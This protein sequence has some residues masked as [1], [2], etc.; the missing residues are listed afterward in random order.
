MNQLSIASAICLC[1]ILSGLSGCSKFDQLNTNPNTPAKVS[2]DMLATTLI[3]D[4]TKTTYHSGTDFV[5]P[6]QLGK[7][8]CWSS[9]PSTEQ[10]NYFGRTDWTGLTILNNVSKMISFAT[11]P[12]LKNSYTALGHCMRALKFFYMTLQVGDI[13]YSQ[14]LTG[15]SDAVLKPAYDSQKNVFLGIL[16]ELDQA[17]SLF[18]IG[19]NFGGD[20]V[21]NGDITH[22]RKMA[23]SFQLQVLIN[24]YKKTTDPDLQVAQRFAQIV[25]NRPIFQSNADNFSLVF[26]DAA[27][28]RYPF[29][30]VGNQSYVYV[31]VSS[32][33]IDSLK[34]LNDNRLYYYANP[35]PVKIKAG[36]LP[37]DPSAYSGPDPASPYSNITAIASS[38]DYSPI[39]DRYLQLPQGEP[40][41]MLS[42]AQ[43]KFIIAEA[44]IRGW[45][46]DTGE[47][48]YTDGITAAMHCVLDNT[49]DDPR[50]N[51][52]VKITDTYIQN[53]YLT[54]P[55]VAFSSDKSEQ[56]KQVW[57]QSYLSIFLQAPYTAYYEYR[58]TGYPVFTIN[59]A[60][61]LN[62][63]ADKIPNR[64]LYPQSELDYN[65]QNVVD[66]IQRQ[67]AGDDN[68]NLQM[69]LLQN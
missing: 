41:Y 22:W 6:A 5:R 48:Y 66:A 39:N 45:L 60:T 58:R 27:N 35:S 13:P 32:F 19:A 64:Y 8:T 40:V 65:K 55:K 2:S 50:Y 12:A 26:S 1:I 42:Y 43:M 20:P 62:T 59:P 16:K 17:D 14:A 47:K 63:P 21:Y 28:Q 23:N 37:S 34:T 44:C 24:L 53:T 52:G 25:N 69:W 3:L 4:A 54:Q 38:A 49:P 9:S 29:Y 51:H 46:P 10:Y 36:K 31:M 68:V 30:I 56:L 57:L 33:L 15:E 67:Y 11:T 61:N 7:Y 18:A